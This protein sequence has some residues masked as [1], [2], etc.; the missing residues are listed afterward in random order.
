[1]Y[2]SFVSFTRVFLL[3][4][5]MPLLVK[6][7]SWRSARKENNTSGSNTSSP[8]TETEQEKHSGADTLDIV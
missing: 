6:A 5:V 4:V 3:F 1:M 7:L 2:L 8:V